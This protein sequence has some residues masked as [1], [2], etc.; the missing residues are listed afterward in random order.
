MISA[1]V[2]VNGH[3][4]GHMLWRALRSAET[5]IRVAVSKQKS[6]ELVVVLDDPDEVT[7]NVA[8]SFVGTLQNIRYSVIETQYR[9]L[10][11]ARN[12]G[13]RKA[14]GK[15]VAFLDADDIWGKSWLWLIKRH[16]M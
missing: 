15:Y 10:G 9:D 11:L 3:H 13:V 14:S 16:E 4:E 8:K 1:S 5:A 2:I 7:A 12:A 6:C